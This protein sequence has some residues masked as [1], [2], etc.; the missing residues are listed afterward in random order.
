MTLCAFG[1]TL[2]TDRIP[3]LDR[4]QQQICRNQSFSPTKATK[5]SKCPKRKLMNY[6]LIG[7]HLVTIN[8]A[9]SFFL[10]R[11]IG[12][13]FYFYMLYSQVQISTF[14]ICI[15]TRWCDS[16]TIFSYTNYIFFSRIGFFLD[17]F[18]QKRKAQFIGVIQP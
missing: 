4:G 8:T 1:M 7:L 15:L 10:T 12:W 6:W 13:Y 14:I 17:L 16:M 5:Q 3:P 11:R 18:E 2:G 9:I